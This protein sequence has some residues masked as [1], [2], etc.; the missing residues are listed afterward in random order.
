VRGAAAAEA[1]RVGHQLPRVVSG[2]AQQGAA[3][4]AQVL[5]KECE[6]ESALNSTWSPPRLAL[7][8]WLDSGTWGA[9]RLG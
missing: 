9:L 1:A 2:D 6:R 8:T 4:V 5:C 3:C 7:Y